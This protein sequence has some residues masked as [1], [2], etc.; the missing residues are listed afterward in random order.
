VLTLTTLRDDPGR[1]LEYARAGLRAR[2]E[3]IATQDAYLPVLRQ[4]LE[5]PEPGGRL[6]RVGNL[7]VGAAWWAGSGRCGVTVD[8]LF[9]GPGSAGIERYRELL[10][11]IEAEAGPIAFVAGPLPHLTG[12][13]ELALMTARGF[14]P[15]GRSEMVAPAGGGPVAATVAVP[16]G[17]RPPTPSDAEALARLHEVAYRGRFDQYLFREE[18]DERQ[19]AVRHIREIFA[20]RWGPFLPSVSRVLPGGEGIVAAALCVERDPGVLIVDVMTD[21]ERRGRGLGRAT[22]AGT[23]RALA[24]G[25]TRKVY[26]NVTEGNLRAVRLY[27]GLGFVR[28]L[29][30]THDWYHR[31]RVPADPLRD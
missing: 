29:G 19:D 28:S 18:V 12:P 7:V 6:V 24:T 22:L 10:D 8:L 2:G 3:T 5:S 16:P 25:P 21:P 30:P 26:L 31:G 11:R 1:A 23:L 9:L 14:G 13:E 15:F 4:R 27:E 17:L 20:G